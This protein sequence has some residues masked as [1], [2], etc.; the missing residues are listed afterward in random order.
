MKIAV[1]IDCTIAAVLLGFVIYGAWRG[2]FRA[3]A[4]L[5]IAVLS[6]TGAMFAARELTPAATELIR[7]V[8]QSAVTQRVDDALRGDSSENAEAGEPEE[9]PQEA[10][11]ESAAPDGGPSRLQADQ[12][13]RL[14]GWDEGAAQALAEKAE[15]RVRQTGVSLAMAVVDSVME[16]FV[17]MVLLVVSFLVLSLL[18]H[19][20]AK[21][22][23]LAARLPGVSFLNG[24]G[25]ALAGLVQGGLVIFLA[26]W[27]LRCLNA[28][29]GAELVEQT[30]VLR[31]FMTSSP[32]D[33]LFY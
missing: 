25:G 7:P 8:I 10:P 1:I 6:L 29:P 27:L 20:A 33:L 26:V 9:A 21:A 13:L 12:L 18:L 15:D 4:G 11:R 19:L 16:S 32:L 28:A 23:D 17:Y 31:F 5:L 24:L 22:L 2:L 30:H 14:M 3:V